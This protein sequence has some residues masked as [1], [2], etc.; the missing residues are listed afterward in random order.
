MA[1]GPSISRGSG[2]HCTLLSASNFLYL[3][4]N[5]NSGVRLGLHWAFVTYVLGHEAAHA[6]SPSLG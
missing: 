4:K 5:M 3:N 2:G 6:P 1:P